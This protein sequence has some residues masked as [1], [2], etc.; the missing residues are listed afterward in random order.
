MRTEILDY[1]VHSELEFRSLETC[2][3]VGS[4]IDDSVCVVRRTIL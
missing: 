1:S 4:L 2:V 3:R